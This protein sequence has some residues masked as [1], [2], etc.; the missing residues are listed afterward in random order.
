MIRHSSFFNPL[1]LNLENL[2]FI[3][4]RNQKYL[5]LNEIDESPPP[6]HN[7]EQIFLK[8][9]EPEKDDKVFLFNYSNLKEIYKCLQYLD[10][11]INN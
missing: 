9:I 5:V 10:S 8:D 11:Q 1:Y 3:I 2:I 4:K 7:Y 6:D